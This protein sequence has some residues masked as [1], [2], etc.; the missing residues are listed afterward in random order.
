MVVVETDE[1]TGVKKFLPGTREDLMA[2]AHSDGATLQEIA[3]QW[4]VTKERVRQILKMQGRTKKDKGPTD[5]RRGDADAAA[6]VAEWLKGNGPV[7]RE[8]LFE[9]FPGA[10]RR[11][12]EWRQTGLVPPGLVVANHLPFKGKQYTEEEI[13]AS[14][15]RVWESLGRP[16]SMSAAAYD[17]ARGDG[18]ASPALITTRSGWNKTLTEAGVPVNTPIRSYRTSWTPQ[19]TLRWIGVW[20]RTVEV[21][22]GPSSYATYSDWA[23][24]TAGAPSGPTARNILRATGISNWIDIVIAAKKLD[25]ETERNIEQEV[26]GER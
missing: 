23:K 2:Q 19:Q 5:W 1:V 13:R 10:R 26:E 4:G 8:E 6:E 24:R 9:R 22:G 20:Q 21:D 7:T 11:L 18:D 17:R 14:L 12:K 15:R 25:M 16:P 3:D